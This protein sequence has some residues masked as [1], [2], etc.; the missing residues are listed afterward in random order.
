MIIGTAG[1]IDHGKTALVKRLSGIDADRLPEEK[2]RGMTIDLGFAHM[3]LEG[4]DQIG[5]VDVPGH[6]RFIR[7]MVAGATGIDLVLLVVAADDGVMPQTREHLDIVCL[8]G[9]TS[10]VVALSKIDLV[11]PERVAAVTEEVHELLGGTPL[12]SAPVMPVSANTGEG[13]DPLRR[14]LAAGL[15]EVRSRSEAGFFW[16]AM[17]RAFVAP[18]FG[19]VV[20]GTIASGRV[21]KGDHLKLLPGEQAVR[22]RGIQVHN[23]TVD[24]AA[25]GSRCALNLAGVDKQ[26]LRRGIAVCDAGL[27]RVATTADAQVALVRDL[28]RPLKNHSRVRLHSGTAETIAR[29]QWLDP[30]PP[31]P[32]GAGL[33]QLRLD[34]AMPLL[35][36]HRFVLR[37]ESAQRTV[38][39]GVVLDPF[40]RRRAARSPE[41]VERLKS[42]SAMNPDRSL[43]VWLEARGAEGWLLPELAEQL[44]EAPERLE[45]RLARSSDVLREDAEGTTWMAPRGAVE[46]LESRLTGAI[47]EY[48]T[49]HPRVTAMAPATLRSTVCPRLDQRIFRSLLARLV[50]AGQVE[51]ISEGVRPVGHH[52]R[53]SPE[54]AALADRVTSLLAYRDKP[55]PK[56]EA[57]AR[58]LGL[59]AGRLGGFLG[60]LERAGR[61]VRLARGVY[62]TQ[63]DLATWREQ[64]REYVA[65]HEQMTLARFRDEIGVGRGLAILVLEYLDRTGVTRRV[66]DVRVAAST[67]KRERA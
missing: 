35:Y 48:L 22:V 25:A 4:V 14:E 5:I 24:A 60:E 7:N 20:T 29:L 66:G 9:I 67:L 49:D 64:A 42:L 54:D 50:A 34:E 45:E 61:V 65:R 23:R 43:T 1:H 13:L 55:P 12:V 40:A 3:E 52:Q 30:K 51:A 32:G 8:L 44:A 10:G 26:S 17:D 47:S 15:A 62:V 28:A 11:S 18:G 33:A 27:T 19:S 39:G 46:T 21:A 6:E 63:Q 56:L 59:P 37:D 2:R 57:L 38:G 58:E 31:G 41:R 36:G 53:F 16:M